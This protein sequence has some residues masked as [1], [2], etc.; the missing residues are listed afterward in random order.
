MTASTALITGAARGLGLA[1]A[2]ALHRDGHNIVIGD[3]EAGAAQTAA[4]KIDGSGARALGIALDV[5]ATDSVETAIAATTDR[6]G[7]L[8][9]LVTNAGIARP[10]PAAEA[11]DEA[12]T[13][14]LE[15]H[16][17]GTM[18]CCRA[19]FPALAA[20]GRG[21]VV[22]LSSISA[23]LGMA[24]RAPYSA[25]KAGIEGLVRALAVEWAPQAIRVNAVGPG[26]IL[27]E[28]VQGTIASGH[29]DPEKIGRLVPLGRFGTPEEIGETVSFLA[30]ERAGYI[31]GQVLYVDGGAIVNSML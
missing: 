24:H 16:V 7:G 31:T 18:R 14:M 12:W 23:R 9:V 25:A 28:M 22:A 17:K 20:S 30:G 2:V 15:V 4:A 1:A 13:E 6:F 3:L 10:G 19:A 5:R 11:S 27:T 26:Y 21:A 29:L 8:D